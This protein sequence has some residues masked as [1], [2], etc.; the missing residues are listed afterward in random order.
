MW[1]LKSKTKQNK[2][3]KHKKQSKTKIIDKQREWWF[4]EK[5][6]IGERAKQVKGSRDRDF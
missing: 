6:E 3:A 1:N 5:R 2:K 4:P